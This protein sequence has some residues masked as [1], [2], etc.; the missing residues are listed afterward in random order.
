MRK[1]KRLF[2]SASFIAIALLSINTTQ[3]QTVQIQK[4]E[5]PKNAIEFLD[6]NFNKQTISYITQEKEWFSTDY[7]VVL[8]DQTKIDFDKNGNWEE[9]E[10]KAKGIPTDFILPS[11]SKYVTTNFPSTQIIKIEKDSNKYDV[12]LSNS[13]ELVFNLKGNFTRIDD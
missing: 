6:K 7:T 11:I 5:L 3:A 9:V 13:L 2:V 1:L 10:N 12:K 8:E 4:Q